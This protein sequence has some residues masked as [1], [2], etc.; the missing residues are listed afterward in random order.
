MPV[1]WKWLVTLGL[2]PSALEACRFDSCY[3]YVNTIE[4]ILLVIVGI[5]LAYA[6][7]LIRD[8]WRIKHK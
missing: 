6:A 2:D 3:R 7:Y 8:I 4:S 1:W 5:E